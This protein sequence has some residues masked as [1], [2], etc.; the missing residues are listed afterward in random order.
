MAYTGRSQNVRL[1]LAE[2]PVVLQMQRPSARWPSGRGTVRP[3][4]CVYAGPGAESLPNVVINITRDWTVQRSAAAGLLVHAGIEFLS[5]NGKPAC[6]K[7][8]SWRAGAVRDRSALNAKIPSCAALR[9]WSSGAG[10]CT[11]GARLMSYTSF[12]EAERD[13]VMASI[14]QTGVLPLD[15]ITRVGIT[16]PETVFAPFDLEA[17]AETAAPLFR[18]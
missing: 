7:A 6:V 4:R 3:G 12:T 15:P 8:A 1:S 10:G 2:M 5:E 14:W 13:G 11:R 9:P 18:S 17:E 16:I